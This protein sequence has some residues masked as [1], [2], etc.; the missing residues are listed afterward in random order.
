VPLRG[1]QPPGPPAPLAREF[2]AAVGPLARSAADLRLALRV[3]GGPLRPARQ[4]RLD[5]FRVGVVLD[6]PACPVTGEVGAA[7][8][9][10]VDA[11]ARA[12]VRIRE[13]WPA[14]VD[15]A[16]QAEAFGFQVELFF[17]SQEGRE[18]AGTAEQEQRRCAAGAAWARY[19]ADV[20]VFLCPTVFTTAPAHGDRHRY[21]DQ[22]FWIA[23]ASLPG[24]PAVSA[25]VG[26]ARPAGLQVVG[27]A[28]EDDT[29]I[30][31]AELAAD[32]V[33][34]FVPPGEG[35]SRVLDR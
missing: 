2:P 8:S 27:P 5:G 32:V 12:G 28:H 6:D 25:P 4:S 16:A 26:G 1:F 10:A 11:L 35:S 21:D 33:G 3:T 24:L 18:P 19:F 15:P 9:D 14:D 17:A 31:F 34:G 29:A 30:T 7:L 20:D 22:V 13:G 23:Q